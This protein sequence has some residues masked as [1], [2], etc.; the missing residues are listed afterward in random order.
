MTN[1][2]SNISDLEDFLWNLFTSKLIKTKYLT[3]LPSTNKASNA[4]VIDI[5]STIR[6]M[7]GYADGNVVLTIYAKPLKSGFR[8]PVIG[9]IE[10]E[11]YRLVEAND[12]PKYTLDIYGAYND[13]D[14]ARDYHARV[15][16]LRINIG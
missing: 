2:Y 10:E 6:D 1:N 11:I 3:E 7:N 14:A 12:N 13:Y 8:S 16:I 15:M 4:L 5:P 9:K